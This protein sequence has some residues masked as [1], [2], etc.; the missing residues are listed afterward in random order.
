MERDRQAGRQTDR[1]TETDRD[2]ESQT[3]L[4]KTQFRINPLSRPEIRAADTLIVFPSFISF[5]LASVTWQ[6]HA[7]HQVCF[8]TTKSKTGFC[9]ME[10]VDRFLHDI[11]F[12]DHC[13]ITSNTIYVIYVIYSQLFFRLTRSD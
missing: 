3:E 13:F 9:F 5:F 2:G 8:A 7:V 1:Q 12:I 6:K 10:K 11:F 4:H